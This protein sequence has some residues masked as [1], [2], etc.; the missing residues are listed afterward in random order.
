MVL[1]GEMQKFWTM[2]EWIDGATIQRTED[3][4]ASTGFAWNFYDRILKLLS[5]I[6]T[7]APNK[8]EFKPPDISKDDMR[9]LK[10]S[11]GNF[12][13][14]GDGFRNG[15]LE[16][17]LEE[18]DDLKESIITTLTGISHILISSKP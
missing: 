8:S 17:I 5:I 6:V 18:S 4:G 9:C 13:L 1:H 10:E 2:E 14:W 3:G 12:Y 11:L 15:M 16:T 7:R